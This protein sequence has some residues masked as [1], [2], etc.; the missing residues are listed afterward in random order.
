MCF[1]Y[2][3]RLEFGRLVIQ[4]TIFNPLR[5]NNSLTTQKR[6]LIFFIFIF[7]IMRQKEVSSKVEERSIASLQKQPKESKPVID[8]KVKINKKKWVS[9]KNKFITTDYALSLG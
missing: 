2:A 5:W 1:A 7:K 9:S 8:N 3:E 4:K 6:P